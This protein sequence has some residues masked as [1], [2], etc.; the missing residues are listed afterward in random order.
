MHAQRHTHAPV[1]GDTRRAMQT[2][3]VSANSLVLSHPVIYYSRVRLLLQIV[4]P[5]SG[6]MKIP[7]VSVTGRVI[8]CH[9]YAPS[10]SCCKTLLI[11]VC[12]HEGAEQEIVSLH[13]CRSTANKN[14]PQHLQSISMELMMCHISPQMK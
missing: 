1:P 3:T 8:R 14:S 6:E 7:E 9:L 10:M 4:D 11:Q 2:L 12:T 13:N 5:V